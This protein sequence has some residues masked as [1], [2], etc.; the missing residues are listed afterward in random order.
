MEERNLDM[1]IPLERAQWEQVG[2]RAAELGRDVAGFEWGGDLDQ[3]HVFMTSDEARGLWSDH[4]SDPRSY[5]ESELEVARVNFN[6]GRPF[7]SITPPS[8]VQPPALQR[9][10]AEAMVE[11]LEH[12]VRQKWQRLLGES[13]V[14]DDRG[15]ISPDVE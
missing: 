9:Q 15:H 8:T 5:G 6:D 7:A 3:I 14:Q 4:V 13:G 11:G 10:E 2:R 1:G 12:F